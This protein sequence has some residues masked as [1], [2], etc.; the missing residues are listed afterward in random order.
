MEERR[1]GWSKKS[2]GISCRHMAH[3]LLWFATPCAN[4]RARYRQN[5]QIK[6]T[7]HSHRVLEL[8]QS[9]T[10][11]TLTKFSC[12]KWVFNY[13]VHHISHC[14]YKQHTREDVLYTIHIT[15]VLY[16]PSHHPL[17]H[18]MFNQAALWSHLD[19]EEAEDV[20][21]GQAYRMDTF[22]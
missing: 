10:T 8:M 17:L 12:N 20:C 3:R 5:T 6:I 13:W 14:Q 4:S 11:M 18:S 21:A 7:L 2:A 1:V 16:W 19:T 22:L 9:S 15:T